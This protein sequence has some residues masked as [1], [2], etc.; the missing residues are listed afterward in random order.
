M[1]ETRSWSGPGS[2]FAWS[3]AL[4]RPIASPAGTGMSAACASAAANAMNPAASAAAPLRESAPMMF[5]TL[6]ERAR[7]RHS[8]TFSRGVY[9]ALSAVPALAADERADGSDQVT[10][11]MERDLGLSPDQAKAQDELQERALKLDDELKS[12]LGDAYAGSQ[13]DLKSG[14]LIVMVSDKDALQKASEAGA[15]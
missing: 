12:T 11:A 15:D 4:I 10:R 1:P 3:I 2:W 13:Y 14:K 5:A 9:L 8:R 6:T 7:S